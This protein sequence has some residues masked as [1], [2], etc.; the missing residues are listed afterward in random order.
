MMTNEIKNEEEKISLWSQIKEDFSVPKLNDP[1]FNSN[2]EIFFN[3]PGVWAIINHRV[4]H[5][6]YKKGFEKLSRAISGISSFFTKTDIHPAASIGRRVF[7]DH[8]IGVVIGS[9]SIIEDDVLIA[10]GSTVTGDVKKG[11]LYLTRAKA[12][13][14]DGYFYKHFDKAKKV[15]EEK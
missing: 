13:T 12:K 8:A 11:E 15:K 2:L 1:A 4:A 9:T 14:I 5:I 3:Y 10:A 6:L 7:L